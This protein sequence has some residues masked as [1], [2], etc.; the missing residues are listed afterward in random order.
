MIFV[1]LLLNAITFFALA[2]APNFRF[3]KSYEAASAADIINW[4]VFWLIFV[5][6]VWSL[7]VLVFSSPGYIRLNYKYD[8]LKMSQ[9]DR[10][11]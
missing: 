9:N 3:G 6:T 5:L 11:L 10:I 7:L 4:I 8:P 2:M 1:L